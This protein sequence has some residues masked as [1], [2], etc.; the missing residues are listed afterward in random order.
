MDCL[1][2]GL[3]CLLAVTLLGCG[4]G[5]ATKAER[6]AGSVAKS[7]NTDVKTSSLA[8]QTPQQK[9]QVNQ[10]IKA[11]SSNPLSKN[12]AVSVSYP[13]VITGNLSQSELEHWK[14]R[15]QRTK[16]AIKSMYFKQDPRE[17]VQIWL[18]KDAASYFQYNLSLWNASPSTSFG[19]YLP[20]KKRMAMNIATGG[21]TLTHEL[22]HPYIEA[23]FPRSPLWFHEGLAS[24][25]EQAYYRSGKV[26]GATNWRLRGLQAV[27]N[28]DAMPSLK[29]MMQTN[30]SQFLGPNREIYYAQARYLMF[31]LQSRGL[32]QKYYAQ[33]SADSRSDPT[34]V[35]TL[36]KLTN[37]KSM[38]RLEIDW[39]R[40]VRG[41]R[42]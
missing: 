27:I 34:G 7:A 26:F 8:R 13:Y 10:S 38:Q 15:I 14:S 5:E 23:N 30:R 4:A 39:V 22:V 18:F 37:F 16:A 21:G 19:Y 42:F 31:Y 32:L 24:L 1:R 2:S 41:L 20:E 25:Y 17:I 36:L 6:S 3:M 40:F 28:A 35:N 33:F 11:I 29:Q 9:A 12:F